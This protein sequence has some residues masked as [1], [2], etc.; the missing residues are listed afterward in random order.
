MQ[1]YTTMNI[2]CTTWKRRWPSRF[3]VLFGH[4]DGKCEYFLIRWTIINQSF[5]DQ[6]DDNT[7]YCPFCMTFFD[8]FMKKVKH[9]DQVSGEYSNGSEDKHYRTDQFI[10]T[11]CSKCNLQLSLK[12]DLW[13]FSIIQQWITIWFHIYQEVQRIISENNGNWERNQWWSNSFNRRQED[14]DW[15]KWYPIQGLKLIDN[16]LKNCSSN[17]Q[18]RFE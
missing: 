7:T 18:K 1:W 4:L 16:S 9:H 12:K 2:P 6:D 11:C 13:V 10:F 17:T 8:S 15:I 14:D 5:V 3:H